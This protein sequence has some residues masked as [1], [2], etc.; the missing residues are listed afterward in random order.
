MPDQPVAVA[1][2]IDSLD[3]RK[4]PIAVVGDAHVKEGDPV[5]NTAFDL[6]R[7]LASRG[8]YIICGGRFGVMEAVCKGCMRVG[9]TSI[10]VLPKNN[11]NE[12]N[13]YCTII[14]PTVLGNHK[15]HPTRNRNSV[16]V[17]G[18]LCVFA[19]AGK[20]GTANELNLAQENE[21]RIFGLHNPGNGWTP[22]ASH[23]GSFTSHANLADALTACG[24]YIRDT[25]LDI[26]W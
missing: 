7:N 9:G 13:P 14:I 5:Y 19:I 17:A 8:H 26:V 20:E 18:A 15:A 12:A 25:Y 23:R 10:G 1:A 2:K 3:E 16:I 21:R 22:D 11:I 6:G 24:K 4:R